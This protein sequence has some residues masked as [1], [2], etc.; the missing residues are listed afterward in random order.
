MRKLLTSIVLLLILLP[1]FS[2]APDEGIWIPLLIEK[3]NIRLMKENPTMKVEISGH[4]DNIGTDAVN[5]RI[6][7]QRANSVA[8]YLMAGA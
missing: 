5:Q 3:Y 7:E 1:V 4:T 2:V 6:S 8:S